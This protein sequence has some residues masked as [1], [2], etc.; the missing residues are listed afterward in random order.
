[1]PA[2]NLDQ[3][4]VILASNAVENGELGAK[5][6]DVSTTLKKFEF[7]TGYNNEYKL[8][9]IDNNHANFKITNLPASLQLE[10]NDNIQ[11]NYSDAQTGNNEYLSVM[12]TQKAENAGYAYDETKYYG[13]IKTLNTGDETGEA[14]ITLQN[15]ASGDYTLKIFNEQCNGNKATDWASHTTDIEL[16]VKNSYTPIPTPD[17]YKE[18][19]RIFSWNVLDNDTNATPTPTQT[20]QIEKIETK[21]LKDIQSQLP[22][23]IRTIGYIKGYGDGTFKPDKNITRAEAAQ[24]IYKLIYNGTRVNYDAL[25]KFSDVNQTSWYSTAL[26]YLTDQG[27]LDGDGGKFY[28]NRQITRAEISKILYNALLKYDRDQEKKL[29]YGTNSFNFTDISNNWSL[30]P[31]KQLATNNMIDGYGDGT[32]KSNQNITRAESV[33]IIAKVFGRSQEFSQRVSFKDVLQSHWAYKYIMNAVNG[34][35]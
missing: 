10:Q 16:K 2:L 9:M 20:K 5:T 31:I 33:A 18:N 22:E 29:V 3:S 27:L 19:S 14:T 8:T 35:N 12:L 11:I 7:P 34:E 6:V 17:S 25:K 28:P 32:F 30:E 13:K 21:A 24:M 4:S 1:M 15:I 23:K 26:A